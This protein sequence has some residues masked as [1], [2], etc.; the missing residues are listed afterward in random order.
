[1]EDYQTALDAMKREI[2]QKQEA[3]DNMRKKLGGLKPD[4]HDEAY[5][6][7]EDEVAK[8]KFN[9]RQVM[10][11]LIMETHGHRLKAGPVIVRDPAR[12]VFNP[13]IL[14]SQ[15]F[16]ALMFGGTLLALGTGGAAAWMAARI[17][18]HPQEQSAN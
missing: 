9:Y 16:L 7:L 18:R 12:A 1:M 15:T 17:S 2:E 14:K 5:Y 4:W 8:L 10:R 6:R 3:L 13:I 11:H